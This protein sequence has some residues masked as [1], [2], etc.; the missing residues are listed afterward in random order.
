M[1]ALRK[2][3]G[4][5][6]HLLSDLLI[7][8]VDVD[9]GEIVLDSF[10][11]VD[12]ELVAVANILPVGT[13]KAAT[14]FKVASVEYAMEL[15]AR[16]STVLKYIALTDNAAIESDLL[17][18][19]SLVE[20]DEAVAHRA[21]FPVVPIVNQITVGVAEQDDLKRLVQGCRVFQPGD[22]R[23][24]CPEARLKPSVTWRH[25]LVLYQSLFC[26]LIDGRND[27]AI[28]MCWTPVAFMAGVVASSP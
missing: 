18:C 2:V 8:E 1:P 15:R 26:Q 13:V 5:V 16:A 27:G 20:G 11:A 9:A 14:E 28:G 25:L 22:E 10:V 7:E 19:Q 17:R 12:S 24:R 3:I 23:W 21:N 4:I 6:R